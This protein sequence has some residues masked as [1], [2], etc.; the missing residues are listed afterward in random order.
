MSND[1]RGPIERLMATPEFAVFMRHLSDTFDREHARLI[2]EAETA[3][4]EAKNDLAVTRL[5]AADATAA[6]A[7]K[8]GAL[9]RDLVQKERGIADVS[10]GA[11][12]GYRGV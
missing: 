2:G 3:A 1:L 6:L 5:N 12:P 9:P 8:I 11:E 7:K 4:R 10:L